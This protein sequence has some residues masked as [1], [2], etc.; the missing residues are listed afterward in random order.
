MPGCGGAKGYPG[1]AGRGAQEGRGEPNV[2]QGGQ[3][4]FRRRERRKRH[5]KAFAD[6]AQK[7][8]STTSSSRFLRSRHPARI[9]LLL[10]FLAVAKHYPWEWLR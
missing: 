3:D 8:L 10:N 5:G 9:P 2:G 1:E 6:T 4:R 7:N